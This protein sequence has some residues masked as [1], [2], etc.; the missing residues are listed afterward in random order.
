LPQTFGRRFQTSASAQQLFALASQPLVAPAY[1]NFVTHVTDSGKRGI[2][3]LYEVSLAYRFLR[4]RGQVAHRCDEA[5]TT[6]FLHHD[7]LLAQFD[8]SFEI[9][10]GHVDLTCNYVSKAAIITWLVGKV[11]DRALSQ[12]ASAM[13]RYAATLP[14]SPT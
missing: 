12:A 1:L 2:W 8:A 11:L 14:V 9:A 5:R 4:T 6:I 10:E 3:A 13:D 7:G